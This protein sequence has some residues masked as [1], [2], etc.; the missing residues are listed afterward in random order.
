M[1][2]LSG[3]GTPS[4]SASGDM[5]IFLVTNTLYIIYKHKYELEYI[6]WCRIPR[7]YPE[8]PAAALS[9]RIVSRETL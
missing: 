5:G 1:G 3:N 9:G 7:E 4:G 8:I 2:I 6:T